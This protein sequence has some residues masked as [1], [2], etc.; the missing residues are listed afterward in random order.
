MK[1]LILL[2]SIIP[3]FAFACYCGDEPVERKVA[4][5]DFIFIGVIVESYIDSEKTIHNKLEI[6]DKIK[7]EA[8]SIWLT[9]ETLETSTCGQLT[10]VG[11]RYLVFG[12]KGTPLSLS[13]CTYTQALHVYGLKGLNE[14]QEAVNKARQ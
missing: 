6:Q 13:S 5:S 2:I 10:S 9:N 3:S 8:D 12:E 4:D 7:G 14:V 1:A 11:M